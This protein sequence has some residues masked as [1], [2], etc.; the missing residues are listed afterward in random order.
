MPCS[1]RSAPAPYRKCWCT[2]RSIACSCHRAS[3]AMPTA[4]R[5]TGLELL[6]AAAAE[7]LAR[8]A[9]RARLRMPANAGALRSRL[10]AAQAVRGESSGDDASIE[11]A[12]ELPD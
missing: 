10:Y 9:R 5:R 7:R 3:I 11:L 8:F 2:T 6:A 12:V 4:E 1:R